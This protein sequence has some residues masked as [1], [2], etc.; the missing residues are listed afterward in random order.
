[1][2]T[3]KIDAVHSDVKFKVKHMLVSNVTGQFNTFD[4]TIETG[5][6]DFKDAKIKF[7][8]DIN[9][10]DT[11]NEM[12]DNHLKSEDFFDAANFPKLTF[13]SKSFTRKSD[14]AF[15]LT[16]DMTI[17]GLTKEIKLEVTYNGMVKG[18]D[19][20]DIAGF[21]IR[22]KINRFDFNLHWNALTETGGFAVGSDIKLDI[23]TE[24]KKVNPMVKAA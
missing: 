23:N 17:R 22:G 21:E 19:G 4:G 15:E 24:L 18:M 8:A 9:S 3:W 11:R 1:M 14:D 7:E 5:N 10:I 6:E 16:G 20:S 13:V 2:N 12:R